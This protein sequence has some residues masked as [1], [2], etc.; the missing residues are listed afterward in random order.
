MKNLEIYSSRKDY[1]GGN[2]HNA[3]QMILFFKKKDL[4]GHVSEK[5]RHIW[6]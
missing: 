2:S 6:L 4:I 1:F 3:N 5:L